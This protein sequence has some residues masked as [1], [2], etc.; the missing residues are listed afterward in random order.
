MLRTHYSSQITKKQ[1]GETVIIAGWIKKIRDI[2]KVKFII[3]R[4]REGDI[5][6]TAK[7]GDCPGSVFDSIASL[8][9]ESVIAVKGAVKSSKTAPSGVEI[10]PKEIAVIGRAET[11]LPLETDKNIKSELETRLNYRFIDLRKEEVSAV[12]KIKSA[13]HQSFIKYMQDNDFTFMHVPCIV[14]AATEGGTNLYPVSY[15]EKEAFLSQSPQLYKQM[16]MASGIDKVAIITPV[17]RAEEHNTTRHLN[18]STQLDIEVAFVSDEEDA[19]RHMESVI[20]FI[21]TE[22][23]RQCKEQLKLLNRNLEIPKLPFKRLTYD[24]ALQ[25]LKKDGIIIK[26]GDDLTPEGER[27]ICRHFNPVIVTKWPTDVRAFYAMP[28][29]GNEKLCRAYDM[30]LDGMEVNSGAQRQHNHDLLVKEMKRR[31]M[32][33]KNFSFYLDAF[34][35]GMP[36]H[37]GWSFGLERLTMVICGLKNIREAMLWP[38]DRTRLTP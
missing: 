32:N 7:Q 5:Q 10:L 2:G 14:A 22:V 34:R 8:T 3:V 36:P 31:K 17:F 15:F 1:D 28:E 26:W 24:N 30:L 35:Y 21:Y 23:S 16:L 9:R 4:D 25:L 18:E 33:P 19:L 29:P 27:A 12:F 13:I 20:H 11:P 38:R 6:V 37:A